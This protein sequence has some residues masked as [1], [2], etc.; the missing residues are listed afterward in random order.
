MKS[1]PVDRAAYEAVMAENERLKQAASEG[2]KVISRLLSGQAQL[3]RE[4]AVRQDAE[5]LVAALDKVSLSDQEAANHGGRGSIYWNNAVTACKSELRNAIASTCL[6]SAAGALAPLRPVLAMVLQALDR[7]AAEGKAARGEMAAELRA[8]IAIAAAP[9]VQPVE[10]QEKPQ[11]DV[12]MGCVEQSSRIRELE[13]KMDYYTAQQ[14]EQ[15]PF[16]YINPLVVDEIEGRRKT[17]PGG[18]TWS[19][20]MCGHWTYP[21]YA[22]PP[23]VPDVSPLVEALRPFAYRALAYA[24]TPTRH[25]GDGC[26]LWLLNGGDRV[27]TVGDLRRALEALTTYE[28]QEVPPN[29]T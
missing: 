25:I 27:L 3:L 26:Q 15:K 16:M 21:L 18:I 12:C 22:S 13:H 14:A 4:L 19:R 17:S 24:N 20:G 11:A 29:A 6:P 28:K 2:A 9:A 1:E 7:D 23:A 10:Q 5:Y 8:A